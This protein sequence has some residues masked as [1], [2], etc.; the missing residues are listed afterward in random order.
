MQRAN[1]NG[2]P[3]VV[4][5]VARTDSSTHLQTVIPES[6]QGILADAK[7]SVGAC[8]S[9]RG[10]VRRPGSA[11]THERESPTHRPTRRGGRDGRSV[12]RAP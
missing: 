7:S 2:R 1:R 12:I 5:A 10:T 11:A 6:E 8:G 9:T 4:E 3:S